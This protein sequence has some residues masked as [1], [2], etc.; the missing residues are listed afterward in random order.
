MDNPQLAKKTGV[1]IPREGS[2]VDYVAR[3]IANKGIG[4][5]RPI[6]RPFRMP[7]QKEIDDGKPALLGQSLMMQTLRKKMEIAAQLK[8]ILVVGPSGAGK[9]QVAQVLHHMSRRKGKLVFVNAA[10]DAGALTLDGLFGHVRGAFT[11]AIDKRIGFFVE[12]DGG[13]LFLDEVGDMPIPVQLA[14]LRVLETGIVNPEGTSEGIKV[15]VQVICATNRDLEALIKLGVFREE[16]YNRIT[17]IILDV[18]SLDQRRGDIP[19]LAQHFVR[20][21]CKELNIATKGLDESALRF[22]ARHTFPNQVR[23]LRDLM[24]VAVVV[25]LKDAVLTEKH[26]AVAASLRTRDREAVLA[27]TPEPMDVHLARAR[28]EA[29][30]NALYVTNGNH[31]EAA[32]LLQSAPRRSPGPRRRAARKTSR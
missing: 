26:L 30:E 3:G 5:R 31:K 27:H 2:I 4:D 20:L 18:P 1:V 24:S 32:R 14:L 8:R 21:P 6:I 9:E 17:Q 10:R 13:T 23:S 7:T 11:G 16:L 28:R 29:I 12:A 22:L 25:G 15:D 19:E